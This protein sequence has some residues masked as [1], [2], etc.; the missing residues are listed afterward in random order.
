MT[1]PELFVIDTNAIVGYFHEVFHEDR[2]VSSKTFKLIQTALCSYEGQIKLSI[3]S[4][5]FVEIF[6][7]W[8]CNEEFARKFYYEVLIPIKESPNIEIKSIDKE[9]L[10]EMLSISGSLENHDLHDK[11]ILASAMSLGCKLITT[12][13]KLIQYVEKTHIIPEIII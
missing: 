11:I 12:D 9:V 6:E 4:I 2:Q 3:P 1:T 5:V 8:F 10:C 13:N 7:K